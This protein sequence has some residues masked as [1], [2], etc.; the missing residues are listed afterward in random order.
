MLMIR[1]IIVLLVITAMVLLG[2][3]LLFNDRKYLHYFRQTI[4]Y[5]LSVLVVVAVF[6]VLRRIF[7]V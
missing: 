2:L 1:L 5:T 6:F 3:Y 4:K 7:Y